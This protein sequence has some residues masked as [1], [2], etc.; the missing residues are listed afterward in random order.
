[1][2]AKFSLPALPYGPD[3]L[4][5]AIS[6]ATFEQHHNGHHKAYVDKLNELAGP[7]GLENASLVE[8]IRKRADAKPLEVSKYVSGG[9]L[10]LQAAQHFNHSFY[11]KSLS[12]NGGEPSGELAKAIDA[13]FGSTDNLKAELSKQGAGHFASGWVW[14]VSIGGKLSV[15]STHDAQTPVIDNNLKPILTIDVWEHA[16][17]LDHKRA[18]K[19][20]LDAVVAKHLNWKFAA[21]A[22][23][24]KNVDELDLGI[25]NG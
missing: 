7:A 15:V 19:A 20:Y 3:T 16:Y 2:A 14:L 22:Y 8:I 11:W 4:S 5:P 17:Y 12:P 9:E 6:P 10:F 18:R 23:A 24:A 25:G 1:M 13:A 21:D